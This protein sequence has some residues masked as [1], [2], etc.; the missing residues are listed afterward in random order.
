[1]PLVYA[2]SNITNTISENL[3]V[4][5]LNITSQ[6]LNLIFPEQYLGL[7]HLTDGAILILDKQSASMYAIGLVVLEDVN[8]LDLSLLALAIMHGLSR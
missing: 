1:L 2:C 6:I 3:S 5:S 8:K 4:S 7:R